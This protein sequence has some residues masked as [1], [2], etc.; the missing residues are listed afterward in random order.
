MI[1]FIAS[2][3][4]TGIMVGIVVLVAKRRPPGQPLTWGEAFAAGTFMF[5]LM[6]M[7]YGV[8]PDRWLRWADNELRWRSDK[9]GIP[10]GP[11]HYLGVPNPLFK[12]G[13]Y[14]GAKRGK[15]VLTAQ[16]LRDVV[17]AG[18]YVAF[19]GAQIYAWGWWQKRGKHVST[20]PELETSAYGRPLVRKV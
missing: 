4:V 16:V 15:V 5:A 14:L 2:L 12:K 3:V 19:L 20:A 11:L 10:T 8:V 9:L 18:I 1:A 17:V 7:I 6:L 13:V